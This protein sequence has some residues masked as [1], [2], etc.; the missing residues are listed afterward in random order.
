MSSTDDAPSRPTFMVLDDSLSN[1]G[2]R[3]ERR[4][5]DW[6]V[7]EC[8]KRNAIGCGPVEKHILDGIELCVLRGDHGDPKHYPA[9]PIR[10][11]DDALF[12]VGMM[13]DDDTADVYGRDT[14]IACRVCAVQGDAMV[15]RLAFTARHVTGFFRAYYILY[16]A[17]NTSLSMIPADDPRFLPIGTTC[18]LLLRRQ[19]GGYS[20][21]VLASRVNH[22]VPALCLWSLPS[23]T[24]DISSSHKDMDDQWVVKDR[25]RVDADRRFDVHVALSCNGN[26]VWC[27]LTQGIM[28]CSYADDMLL[29][30]GEPSAFRTMGLVGNSI[31][32]VAI[33]PSDSST[34]DTMVDVWTLDLTQRQ[35]P[36]KW[37]M[38]INFRMQ[39]MWELDDTFTQNKLPKTLPRFPILR[40]EDVGIL[41]MLL[42]NPDG[43]RG[44]FVG[45]DVGHTTS[46]MPQIVS[47]TRLAVPWMRRALVLPRDFFKPLDVLD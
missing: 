47:S 19:D 7:V 39:S 34:G 11:S 13:I 4:W 23:P 35:V 6:E 20:L 12:H 1:Y 5:L 27:D 2:R 33:T 29:E 9:M 16:N 26:A 17:A 46:K 18:P 25:D 44:H 14:N 21:A 31:W 36:K 32:F 43:T 10:A 30:P 45:I 28:Y 24:D 42:P 38:H 8:S 3:H 37:A 15:I 41:Y 40:Q 22:D